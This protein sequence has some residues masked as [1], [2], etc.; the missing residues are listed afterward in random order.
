M[1][2]IYPN[3]S[4][5]LKTRVYIGGV[6]AD[7][8]EITLQVKCGRHG[9]EL[10]VTPTKTDTGTYEGAVIPTGSGNH[11]YRWDTDGAADIADEGIFNVAESAFA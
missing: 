7:A 5:V 8:P 3:Q 11:Y 2:R 6:L 1:P 9:V 4:V 10:Q